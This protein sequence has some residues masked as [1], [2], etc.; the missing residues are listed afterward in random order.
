MSR[1]LK[2]PSSLDVC[3]SS[4]GAASRRENPAASR[5]RSLGMLRGQLH[6]DDDGWVRTQPECFQVLVGKV[7][8]DRLAQVPTD[9]VQGSPLSDDG[10]FETLA[11]EAGL[12]SWPDH[13]LDR[14]LKHSSLRL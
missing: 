1:E 8:F 11:D 14:P 5:R 13:R 10:D 3:I 4:S 7:K 2:D 6:R 12:F 9:L